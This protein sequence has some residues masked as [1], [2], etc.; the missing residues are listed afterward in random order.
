MKKI[1]ALL[2]ALMM[3]FAFAAC[4][5][6]EPDDPNCGTY[7]CTTAEMMG[8]EMDPSEFYD[9]ECSIE[10][11][12]GGKAKMTLDSDSG[13]GSWVVDGNAITIT[14]DGVDSVGTIEDG[15]MVIDLIGMGI[16]FTF[17]RSE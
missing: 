2:L 12:N 9:S 13:S 17:E 8:V 16:N 15:V 11:K 6:S 14:I 1:T 4:G 3:V 10:L 7:H 5:S